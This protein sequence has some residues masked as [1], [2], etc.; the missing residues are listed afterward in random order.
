MIININIQK[1]AVS[2]KQELLV[3]ELLGEALGEL[4]LVL[5]ELEGGRY[6]ESV[7]LEFKKL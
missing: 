3:F 4:L 2:V 5:D 1:E 6:E 7:A